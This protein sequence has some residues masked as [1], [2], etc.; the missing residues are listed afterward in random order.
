LT[1]SPHSIER[2]NSLSNAPNTTEEHSLTVVIVLE[3]ERPLA[4]VDGRSGGLG[5][6]DVLLLLLPLLLVH[7]FGNHFDSLFSN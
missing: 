7:D 6:D 2:Y 1:P 3:E 4:G 5:L